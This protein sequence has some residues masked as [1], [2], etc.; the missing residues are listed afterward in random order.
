MANEFRVV[1]RSGQY[2][3]TVAFY[4]D[5][6]ELPII[7]SWDNGPGQRGTE[8][9]AG[10]GM[11][12]V[13]EVPEGEPSALASGLEIGY[14]VEDVDEWYH[15][16]QNKGGPIRGELA[17][18]PWGHRTFSLTDPC[19]IRIILYSIIGKDT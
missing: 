18:K 1:F 7:H 17:D 19:G 16:I 8:F 13:L 9:S 5:T 6:L 2:S 12:E 11:I 15:R 10:S 4:R 14:E 3:D